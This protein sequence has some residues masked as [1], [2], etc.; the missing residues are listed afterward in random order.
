MASAAFDPGASDGDA[1]TG[2]LAAASARERLA[3]WAAGGLRWQAMLI[4]LQ[5]FQA[6]NRAFGKPA[7]D[8]ALAEVA[9]R[10]RAFAEDALD[11][12]WFAARID[13]S[14]FLLAAG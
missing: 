13:G 10:I 4:G 6:V 1:L 5:C 11:G 12:E 3:S 8:A 7:G 14:A 2:L 9:R